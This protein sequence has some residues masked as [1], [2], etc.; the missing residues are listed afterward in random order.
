MRLL[1]FFLTLLWLPMGLFAQPAGKLRTLSEAEI[2]A[3]NANVK[4]LNV[5]SLRLAVDQLRVYADSMA[6]GSS[7]AIRKAYC[8]LFNPLLLDVLQAPISFDYP[9]DSL[10][11]LS[12][13]KSP[14]GQVRIYS[15][16]L[17]SREHGTFEYFGVVQRRNAKTGN[18]STTG[19][20]EKKYETN[21]A[22]INVFDVD[23]WYGAVYY[24]I[25]ER[26]IDKKNCYFL[27]G[28]HGNDRTTTRK[29][30]EVLS[31]DFW[32]KPEF[33]LPVFFGQSS[34]KVKYRVIFEFA[35]SAVMLLRYD[36]RMK[37]LVF[38]HLSPANPSLK[39]N[40]SSY[41]PDFTYDG[42]RFKKG[43]WIYRKNLDLRN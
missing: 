24:D 43:K 8:A 34:P 31:F 39:G 16:F 7:D 1:V 35:A 23:E 10:K 27:L 36:N 2:Q 3:R 40:F 9:F 11:T 20:I 26:K 17:Q 41:G 32:D 15:W 14:D 5:D 37:M 42:Y 38:D 6:R 29:V 12:A 22:E 21:F 4:P 33:G 19:L 18:F 13:L 28:W 25:I 30:I